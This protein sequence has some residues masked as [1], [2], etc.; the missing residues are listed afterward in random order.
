MVKWAYTF[1]S[2]CQKRSFL[3]FV[4]RQSCRRGIGSVFY[5]GPTAKNGETPMIYFPQYSALDWAA[6]GHSLFSEDLCFPR[7]WLFSSFCL[8]P[9][10]QLHIWGWNVVVPNDFGDLRSVESPHVLCSSVQCHT[11]QEDFCSSVFLLCVGK[12]LSPGLF[13]ETACRMWRAAGKRENL[14]R[15]CG[16]RVGLLLCY[17]CVFIIEKSF[18]AAAA[19]KPGSSQW[20]AGQGFLLP[21]PF[22]SLGWMN[23]LVCHPTALP[24]NQKPGKLNC[25]FI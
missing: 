1:W 20:D 10:Q 4:S 25:F 24:S 15:R 19:S 21:S 7:S 8:L 14:K 16:T 12:R 23:G 6:F 18:P 11:W 13:A 9:F 3:G 2:C 17:V 22:P 5:E